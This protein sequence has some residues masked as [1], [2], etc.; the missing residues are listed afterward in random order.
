MARKF[1]AA[2]SVPSSPGGLQVPGMNMS[3]II[4]LENSVVLWICDLIESQNHRFTKV[5]KDLQGHPVQ[6]STYHKYFPLNH[7]Q[8][9][10]GS[11]TCTTSKCFL[12]TSRD[13]DSTTS[14]GSPFQCQTTLSGEKCFLIS[15]LMIH[16][17]EWHTKPSGTTTWRRHFLSSSTRIFCLWSLQP[18]VLPNG[19]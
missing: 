18:P 4:A 19:L 1:S 6:P 11:W 15:N 10:N 3:S 5:G 2:S 8:H 7:V 16:L 14:L 17:G 12:N 9:L 13:S